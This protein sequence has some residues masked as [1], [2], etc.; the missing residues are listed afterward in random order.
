M[1]E[2]TIQSC[3]QVIQ[4]PQSSAHIAPLCSRT[5]NVNKFGASNLHSYYSYT[6]TISLMF[7]CGFA[8]HAAEVSQEPHIKNR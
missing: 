2:T 4:N 8:T 5:A 3:L 6:P 7:F 1:S